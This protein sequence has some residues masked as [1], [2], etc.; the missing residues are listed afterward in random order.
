MLV[1]PWLIPS[2]GS[3]TLFVAKVFISAIGFIVLCLGARLYFLA[4]K[5]E[6]SV[7]DEPRVEG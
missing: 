7:S 1:G 3:S 2:G 4:R 6:R 5:R